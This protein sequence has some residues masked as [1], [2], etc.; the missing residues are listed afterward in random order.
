LGERTSTCC[1]AARQGW[2]FSGLQAYGAGSQ[3]MKGRDMFRSIALVASFLRDRRVE[4]RVCMSW[5]VSR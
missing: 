4:R 1:A 2:R 5:G 3:I